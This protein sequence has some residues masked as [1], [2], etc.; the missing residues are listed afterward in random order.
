MDQTQ[1]VGMAKHD[2]YYRLDDPE[3]RFDRLNFAWNF[4]KGAGGLWFLLCIAIGLCVA[5]ST[6]LSGVISFLIVALL[7][8]GGVSQDFIREVALGKNPGGGF[9]EA[10][11]R[12]LSRQTLAAPLEKTATVR[13]AEGIDRGFRFV[14][15]GVLYALPDVTV[16]SKLTDYVA[17][18]FNI[19]FSQLLIDFLLMVGY[20]LPWAVLAYYLLKW[21]EIASTT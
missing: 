10:G 14:V 18:G 21:R 4:L 6:Y 3:G 8:L 15:Q 5:L 20:L 12:L 1:Y 11:Y 17:E 13:V 7:F 9:A 19:P 16:N 2:L